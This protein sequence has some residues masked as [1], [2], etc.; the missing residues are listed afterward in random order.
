MF[1]VFIKIDYRLC[2]KN[3]LSESV[4]NLLK[5]VVNSTTENHSSLTKTSLKNNSKN[6]NDAPENISNRLEM[7]SSAFDTIQKYLEEQSINSAQQINNL[8][9]SGSLLNQRFNR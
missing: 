2:N 4:E 9:V 7:L 3:S 5:R 8:S 1:I 6:G